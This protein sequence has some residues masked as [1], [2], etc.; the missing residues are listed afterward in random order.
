MTAISKL[1]MALID[2]LA[3]AHGTGLVLRDFNPNNLIVTPEEQLRLID[4]ESAVRPG[5]RVRRHYTPGFSAPEQI[6]AS[7]WG[8][9][10]GQETDLFSLGATL[11]HLASG[12]VPDF[13]KDV[14]QRRRLA[15]RLAEFISFMSQDNGELAALAPLILGLMDSDPGQRW[16]L[17]RARKFLRG[18]AA[19]P[20]PRAR[21]TRLARHAGPPDLAGIVHDGQAHLLRTLN[22]DLPLLWPSTDAGNRADPCSVQYGAAGVVAVL[23]RTDRG[24][25]D[26]GLRAGTAAAPAWIADRLAAVPRVLPGLY[27]GRSG[28][29]WALHDVAR[30]LGDENLAA[31]AATLAESVPVTD[32]GFAHGVAGAG[33]FLLYSGVAAKDENLVAAAL[34]AGYTLSRAAVTDGGAARWPAGPA[35]SAGQS[36]QHWCS[37]ASG[38]GTFLIRLWHVTRDRRFL[39]L[40]DAAA[41]TVVRQRWQVGNAACHGLA[42]DG[43]FLLDMARITGEQKYLDWAHQIAAVLF[44]RRVY[45][46]G[47]AVVAGE[48]PTKVTAAYNTGN[49]GVLGFLD[50]L[51]HHGPRLWMPDELLEL[52]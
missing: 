21:P 3:T 20:A 25:G 39:D 46:A 52:S 7:P 28:T 42:G 24:V 1:A 26:P 11:F 32:W 9:A 30:H 45:I 35:E 41:V 38:I 33:T 29:A 5:A 51:L 47:L 2:I 22:P 4:L 40:A 18:D 13:P 10:P 8:P 50:R 49:A 48:V 15:D 6:A 17:D 23:A 36:L 16:P 27:F 12:V 37:G 19:Q 14:P 43:E 31:Q 44:A 34:S